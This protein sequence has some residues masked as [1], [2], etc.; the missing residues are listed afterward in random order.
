MKGITPMPAFGAE[1]TWIPQPDDYVVVQASAAAITL[2]DLNYRLVRVLVNSGSVPG[3]LTIRYDGIAVAWFPAYS[4]ATLGAQ[5]W[6]LTWSFA[7]LN[8]PAA[9]F[10][11]G[12]SVTGVTYT[13]SKGRSKGPDISAYRAIG[14]I[15]T[16]A[17]V[18]TTK[19]AMSSSP[20]TYDVGPAIPDWAIA[21]A[22]VANVNVFWPVIGTGTSGLPAD[23]QPSAIGV[24]MAP[25]LPKATSLALTY[26][27]L[28]VGAALVVVGYTPVGS[29]S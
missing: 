13:F 29:G 15:Q 7:G 24:H 6:A 22:T 26:T 5:A 16:T 9:L 12:A 1:Q 17:N 23:A 4:N 19:T 11:F 2:P 27:A 21:V 28:A 8:L 3:Y 20:V 18:G 25:S 14:Y 10:T